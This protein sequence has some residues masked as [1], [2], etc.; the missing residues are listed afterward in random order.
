MMHL[1]NGDME[2]AISKRILLILVGQR[3][4]TIN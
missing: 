2:N 4:L 3:K 1:G